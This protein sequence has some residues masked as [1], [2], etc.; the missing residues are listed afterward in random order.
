MGNE[1]LKNYFNLNGVKI[2]YE[3][4]GT[5]PNILFI[6]AG[7]ADCRMWEKE[8]DAMSQ[9]FHTLRVDLPGHG[10]SNFSGGSFSN[11]AL[12]KALLDYLHIEQT[13]I[14]AASFNADLAIDFTLNYPEYCK[15]LVLESP[16]LHGW[17]FSYTVEEYSQEEQELLK[18]K[19]FEETANL[20]YKTWILRNRS[21]K[22]ISQDIRELFL[23]MQL[24]TFIKYELQN[25][26]GYLTE[27]MDNLGQLKY[28]RVPVLLINGACDIKDVL[29]ISSFMNHR[30]PFS[31]QVVLE[32]TGHLPNLEKSEMF[33]KIVLHFYW[34]GSTQCMSV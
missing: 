11:S 6:H 34:F 14:I 4:K 27:D 22:T 19:K 26:Y 3:Q 30:L 21:P 2:Y 13:H 20:N 15:S 23:D 25:E 18:N 5:G 33:T 32:N 24:K 12:L 9:R 10:K 8:F 7:M 28:I 29:Q 1:D 17:D 31:E 16:I